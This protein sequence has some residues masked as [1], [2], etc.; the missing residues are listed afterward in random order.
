[1]DP[2]LLEWL[3]LAFDMGAR[4]LEALHRAISPDPVMVFVLFCFVLGKVQALAF[5]FFNQFVL[6]F[7][8]ENISNDSSLVRSRLES[9][10]GFRGAIQNE[11]VLTNRKNLM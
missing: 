4:D 11:V 3:C 10:N 5:L 9:L 2:Q 7:V 1:M 6:Q 8:P